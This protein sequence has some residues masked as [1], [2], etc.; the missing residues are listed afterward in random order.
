[1]PLLF[2]WRAA[3]QKRF[4]SLTATF[5]A[6]HDVKAITITA[7]AT[8]YTREQQSHVRMFHIRELFAI[9]V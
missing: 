4:L 8:A 9:I 1:M 6:S 7:A 5:R 2:V 3:T